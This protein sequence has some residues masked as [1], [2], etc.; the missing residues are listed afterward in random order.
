[1]SMTESPVT[2]VALVAVKMAVT[3]FR[4][5][6][7]ELETG[8]HNRNEP[9][10][11]RARKLHAINECGVIQSQKDDFLTVLFIYTQSQDC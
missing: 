3:G 11:M 8:N 7:F 1:M 2:H 5:F 6:P 4:N 9:I 10:A